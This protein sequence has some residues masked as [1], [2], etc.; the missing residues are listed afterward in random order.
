VSTGPLTKRWTGIGRPNFSRLRGAIGSPKAAGRACATGVVQGFIEHDLLT[1]ASSIAFRVLFALTPFGCFGL[2]LLG[3]LNLSDVWHDHAAPDLQHHVSP[4][5]YAVVNQ[6]A[7]RVLSHQQVFWLTAG[8]AIALWAI[9]GA[10]RAVMSAFDVIY[11]GGRGRPIPK[12]IAVSLAISPVLSL[13]LISALFLIRFGS[14]IYRHDPT[15]LVVLLGTLRWA[16]AA[17]LISAAVG[18]LVH[19]APAQ[20]RPLP[21]V[22]VGTVGVMVLWLAATALYFVYLTDLASYGSV[23]AGLASVIVLMTYLYISA[24]VFLAGAMVDTLLRRR[25]DDGTA[26]ASRR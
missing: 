11:G 5:V 13:L 9:S 16:A 3:F 20:K 22:S 14:I 18:I 24:V 25:A 12:G 1:Y 10:V 8:L 17:G 6:V 4:A 7:T 23:F 21:W 15:V 19:F 26:A 2:A